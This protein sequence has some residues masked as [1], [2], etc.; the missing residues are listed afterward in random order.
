MICRY[1]LQELRPNTGYEVRVSYPA[2]VFLFWQ[3]CLHPQ[4]HPVQASMQNITCR[5]QAESLCNW[6]LA[7]L[8]QHQPGIGDVCPLLLCITLFAISHSSVAPQFKAACRRQLLDTEKV[9]FYTDNEG[10]MQ[11]DK[12]VC[13]ADMFA[14]IASSFC[15][16]TQGKKPFVKMQAEATGIHRDG[17]AAKPTY[18]LFNIG[19]SYVE[20]YSF[21]SCL[22][23]QTV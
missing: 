23:K 8:R 14:A 13:F 5:C 11:V 18:F 17:P 21:C 22:C 2:T 20:C 4:M 7:A 6:S 15:S 3:K 9:I 19:W 16:L 12:H 10:T 1:S